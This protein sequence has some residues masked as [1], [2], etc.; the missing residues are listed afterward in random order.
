M[1]K[2]VTLVLLSLTLNL[3]AQEYNALSISEIRDNKTPKAV[4]WNFVMSI[5]NQDYYQMESLSDA[6]FINEIN[7]W[8]KEIGTT[9]YYQLF[10]E[11]IIHDI[12]GMRPVMRDGWRLVC[13]EEYYHDLSNY[14]VDESY[15]GLQ[16]CSVSFNCMK[17]GQIYSWQSNTEHDTTARVILIYK[18]NKWK[19]LGFK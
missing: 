8:M 9:S 19:V 18:E 1:K 15:M 12:V 14:G 16:A 7:N 5:I 6:L 2:L 10:K 17:D 13:S 4:A 11:E 3:V